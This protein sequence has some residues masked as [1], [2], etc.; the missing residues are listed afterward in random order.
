VNA[1]V[2]AKVFDA[3]AVLARAARAP[4]YTSYPTANHFCA[5]VGPGPYGD[6]LAA[7]PEEASLSL[8]LH[9]PFCA[10]MC[11]YC[12]CTTKAT[13]RYAPIAAYLDTLD[14]EME[15]VAA[16]LPAFHQVRHLH[17]GGGSPDIL[18]PEDMLR[19][20]ERLHSRFRIAPDAE[21]AIEIDPRLMT[22]AKAASLCAIGVNRISV[23]VQDFD[24]TVQAAIGRR[25]SFE[26]TQAAVAMFRARG[27]ASINLDL[28]YGLP[29]QTLDTV[30]ATLDRALCLAPD[31][32][33]LFGY[34]HL[35]ER[36]A[37]QRLIDARAL[38]DLAAR[39]TLS[40]ALSRALTDA[41]FVALG[42]DH[43]A[44]P[45][46]KLARAP[47]KRN[48]QGYTTDDADALIGLGTSAISRLP[49]GYAQNA[50]GAR[51]YA[52][53]I[54]KGGLA[55]V[56][57]AVLTADDRVRAA[58]IS[59]LMCDFRFDGRA[60]TEGFGDAAAGV[61]AI[62]EDLLA[63]DDEGLLARTNDGFR[64]T[65]AGRPFVRIVC[66]AFDAHLRPEA[67]RRHAPSV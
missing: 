63:R 41:G 3:Q 51:D 11:W 31:R 8:Y 54:A 56:R 12:A 64:L 7:L 6:W 60:L 20:G 28:V 37:N 33:A 48:F 38:P 4:R 43:F 17:L 23:G 49:Q 10:E 46:D 14:A 59:G 32:I 39:Y 21:F 16:R 66:A 44:R 19:L 15:R 29:H 52:E 35:P 1:P 13:K 22:Q 36:A 57:G 53:R 45:T 24:E 26:D 55:T 9:V 62:A 50:A 42:V 25:Q 40:G 27:M 34:A 58:A 18:T 47:L 5:A 65:D 61:I 2:A 67:A 30:M